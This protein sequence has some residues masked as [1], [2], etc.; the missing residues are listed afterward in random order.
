MCLILYWKFQLLMKCTSQNNPSIKATHSV[1]IV[2]YMVF[3]ECFNRILNKICGLD[4]W[5]SEWI[6]DFI[7]DSIGFLPTVYKISFMTDQ[8]VWIS[9]FIMDF[10]M[11]IGFLSTVYEIFFSWQTCMHDCC[12]LTFTSDFCLL[13]K[14]PSHLFYNSSLGN[15]VEIYKCTNVSELIRI[16]AL[17]QC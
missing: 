11:K 3:V 7:M 1:I 14:A 12:T 10:W 15:S 9:D 17:S 16:W 4:F 5:I 13:G 8:L 2:K 6:S